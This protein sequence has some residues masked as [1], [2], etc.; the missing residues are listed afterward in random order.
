VQSGGDA[1]PT[2]IMAIAI[3]FVRFLQCGRQ[4]RSCDPPAG[5]PSRESRQ[6]EI[7]NRLVARL[8][9][10]PANVLASRSRHDF[11]R[12]AVGGQTVSRLQP[13]PLATRIRQALRAIRSWKARGGNL[14]PVCDRPDLP[15]NLLLHGTHRR[16]GSSSGGFGAA[17]QVLRVRRCRDGGGRSARFEAGASGRAFVRSTDCDCAAQP[18]PRARSRRG[19]PQTETGKQKARRS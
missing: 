5:R 7:A 6:R 13:A 10:W 15:E 11:V 16:I 19:A 8:R 2:C 9:S 1:L 4:H 18:Q 17:A 12:S 3:R 14:L